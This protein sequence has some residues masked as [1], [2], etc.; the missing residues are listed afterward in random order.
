MG[1][2][3]GNNEGIKQND[4][5]NELPRKQTNSGRLKGVVHLKK[6]NFC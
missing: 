2:N 5:T 3:M 6:K 1:N 4:L